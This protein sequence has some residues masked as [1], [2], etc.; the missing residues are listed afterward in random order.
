[1]SVALAVAV[2]VGVREDYR[3]PQTAGIPNVTESGGALSGVPA[4]FFAGTQSKGVGAGLAKP[5]PS[6]AHGESAAVLR[7]GCFLVAI[8]GIAAQAGRQ[9]VN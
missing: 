5:H 4:V 8:F 6:T 3:P 2:G 9:F 7:S 1:V